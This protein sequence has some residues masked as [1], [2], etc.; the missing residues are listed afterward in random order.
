MKSNGATAFVTGG[1]GFIG[2]R[3]I[4][5]LVRDHGVRVKTL[6]HG[7]D[8]GPGTL[9][10]A[11]W[12]VEFVQA[13]LL[14]EVTLKPAVAGCD[15]VF[16]C[17]CGTRGSVAEQRRVTVDGTAALLSATR[18]AGSVSRFVYLG[19]ASVFGKLDRPSVDEKTAPQPAP[20]WAYAQDKWKAEQLV[21]A[22]GLPWTILRLPSVYGPYGFPF[23]ILPIQELK[24][25]R[26][27]LVD[28]GTGALNPIYVDDVVQGM[29]LAATREKAVGETFLINGP[30]RVTRRELYERFEKLL[31][32]EN[33]LV[34]MTADEIRQAHRQQ[35]WAATLSLPRLALDAFKQSATFRAAL[36]ASHLA[37]LAQAVWKRAR[38]KFASPSTHQAAE[39]A[40]E[41]PL[42]L[43]LDIFLDYYASAAQYDDA[44]ARRLLGYEP[45]YNFDQG[46]HLTGQWAR[47]AR[48][49]P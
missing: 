33:R 43:P 35:R 21:A 32:L 28:G 8:T 15:F 47:W 44:K 5:S 39:E 34:S 9:R 36:H 24:A 31:N 13:D 3:L 49:I 22:S 12:G 41:L 38:Q 48:L 18:E 29:L 23:S 37:P 45:K 7:T 14:D 6:I 42:T 1:T 17:A 10:A 20:K 40:V 2:G 16:H 46:M 26:V 11:R 27:A 4:E 19:S 30:D 25:G